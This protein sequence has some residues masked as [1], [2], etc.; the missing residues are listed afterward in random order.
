MPQY[1]VG[2]LDRVAAIERALPPG[3]FLV[4]PAYRGPGI[5]DCVRGG[6]EAAEA[7]RLRMASRLHSIEG[8]HVR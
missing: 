2:H 5:A 7:V 3:T 6:N 8:E 4:G 1:E